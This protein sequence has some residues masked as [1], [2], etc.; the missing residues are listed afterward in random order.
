MENASKALIIA[1]AILLSI[2]LISLGIMIFTQAQDVVNGSGMN[3]A[4]VTAFNSKFTKYEGVQ[5]G[6]MVRALVQEVQ[7]V[8]SEAGVN[9]DF[10]KVKIKVLSADMT[11]DPTSD[12]I[13]NSVSYDVKV[14]KYASGLVSEI[15]VTKH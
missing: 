3:E 15:T 7:A 10:K 1:G 5:K 14:T 2:L 12:G 6:A 4:Q 8:N 11:E 13:T 9:N